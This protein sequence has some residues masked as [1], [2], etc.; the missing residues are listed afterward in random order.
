MPKLLMSIARVHYFCFFFV[1]K[2]NAGFRILQ[3]KCTQL[4][5]YTFLRFGAISRQNQAVSMP[6]GEAGGTN[7]LPCLRL[8]LEKKIAFS[9]VRLKPLKYICAQEA[10]TIMTQRGDASLFVKL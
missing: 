5:G 10:F 9:L 4:V 3:T 1:G 2:D 8:F 7:I 6:M